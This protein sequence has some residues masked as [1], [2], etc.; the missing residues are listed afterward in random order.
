MERA[1]LAFK[2]TK[3]V[4]KLLFEGFEKIETI[5]EK[6]PNDYVTNIDLESEELIIKMIRG[7]FPGDT[8]VSEER[9]I[10]QGKTNY[11]WILDPLDGTNNYL[12]GIPQAGMQIAILKKDV[13][14]FGLLLD[15]FN[16]GVYYAEKGKGSF[17][18]DP[19]LSKR[20]KLRVSDRTVDRSVVI[21][22]SSLPKDRSGK[23]IE[24]VKK[25]LPKMGSIRIYG[26]AVE[27]FPLIAQGSAEALI[28]FIPKSMDIT[29]GSLLIEEAGG[30]VTTFTGKPWYPEMPTI[31]ATNGKLHDEFLEVLKEH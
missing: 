31:L 9:G 15:V 4:H 14:V 13:A 29:A 27:D 17:K 26:V 6:Y 5:E 22:S 30:R 19:N 20:T 18:T 2:I 16:N 25:L 23:E 1:D 11:R 21:V 8:I 24:T 12:R 7:T 10:L 28:S 3:R